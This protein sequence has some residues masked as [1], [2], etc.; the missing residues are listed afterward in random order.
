MPNPPSELAVLQRL[1]FKRCQ[2]EEW[3][4]SGFGMP[5]PY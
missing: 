2:E 4:Q 1:C 3:V 5:N